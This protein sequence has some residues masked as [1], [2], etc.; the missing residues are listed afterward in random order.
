MGSA[1]YNGEYLTKSEISIQLDDVGFI[2][3]TTVSERLR[4]FAGSVFRLGDHLGRLMQSV[5]TIGLSDSVDLAEIQEALHEVVQRNLDPSTGPIDLGIT[6]LITPGSSHT[7]PNLIIY[8]DSLPFMQMSAWYQQGVQLCTTDFRQV[9]T[10]SWPA[11]LKCRSRM[12]YF[13]ADRQAREKQQGARALLLDQRG[14]VAEASTANLIAYSEAE[15]LLS[16]HRENIL[17]GISLMMV[18]ELARE[19]AI[20]FSYRD[21]T[22]AEL[23]AMDEVMLCSTSPCVWSV[24]SVDD[25]N[26]KNSGPVVTRLQAA[27]KEAVGLDFVEQATRYVHGE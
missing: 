25:A 19:L 6:V 24:V 13:L 17:P 12:H 5:D 1:Y 9:P 10:T 16:P 7:G 3:G 27:W 18:E 15:G 26:W 22:P 11:E 4:T 20:P 23:R 8:A 2:L 14:F 21:F